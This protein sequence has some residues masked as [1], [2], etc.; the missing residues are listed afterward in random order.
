ML[1]LSTGNLTSWVDVVT[2]LTVL[3]HRTGSYYILYLFSYDTINF[4][5]LIDSPSAKTMVCRSTIRIPFSFPIS[6]GW[7]ATVNAVALRRTGSRC[8]VTSMTIIWLADWH[9]RRD[10]C[11]QSVFIEG[12]PLLKNNNLAITYVLPHIWRI[13]VWTFIFI[14]CTVIIHI[15]H[16]VLL[17][18]CINIFEAIDSW[19]ELIELLKKMEPTRTR[20]LN[21]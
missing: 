1:R 2:H 7:I 9:V 15:Y 6:D 19:F 21:P 18:G 12:L 14:T 17:P 3:C 10:V 13:A 8:D 11:M 16:D 20:T 4:P 5:F